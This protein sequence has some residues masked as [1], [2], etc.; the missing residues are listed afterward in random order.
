MQDI[1]H[2]ADE[3]E[4]LGNEVA[5]TKDAYE[6]AK[7]RFE[8][9]TT[10]VIPERVH[11]LGLESPINYAHGKQLRIERELHCSITKV[12]REAAIEWLRD[13]GHA[14]S[15]KSAVIVEFDRK[16]EAAARK[17]FD[18]AKSVAG[19]ENVRLETTVAGA[20]L[21]SIVERR[22]RNGQP[23]SDLVATYVPEKAIILLEAPEE[24]Q[25]ANVS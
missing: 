8:H 24:K 21:R 14:E 20:T 22:L 10:Q 7:A 18:G 4:R 15:I 25:E 6:N 16:Q 5:T 19:E 11:E 1:K 12:D 3:M 13:N 2:L 23:I 9:F 17:F